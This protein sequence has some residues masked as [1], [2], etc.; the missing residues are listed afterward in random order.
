MPI[1][2]ALGNASASGR[3]VLAS[4]A[5]ERPGSVGE[6]S[7]L[8]ATRPWARALLPLSASRLACPA[9]A[10]AAATTLLGLGLG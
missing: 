5:A 2:C 8:P 10:S 9:A 1:C 4:A 6:V 3:R 7:P